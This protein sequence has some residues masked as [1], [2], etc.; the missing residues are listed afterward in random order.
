MKT[1]I[2]AGK[3]PGTIISGLLLV[4]ISLVFCQ[5]ATRSA[6]AAVEINQGN[7]PVTPE[8]DGVVTGTVTEES[9]GNPIQ[10]VEMCFQEYGGS[11]TWNL[12]NQTDGDGNYSITLSPGIYE[13]RAKISGYAFEYYDDAYNY[14]HR[15][16]VTVSDGQ[17]T[18][19]IDFDLSPGGVITGVVIET[20]S[21]NPLAGFQMELLFRDG[22]YQVTQ[23]DAN[24]AYQFTD[25]P[26]ANDFYVFAWDWPDGGLHSLEFWDNATTWDAVTPVSVTVGSSLRSNINF[27]LEWLGTVT[28]TVVYTDTGG[29]IQV[30]DGEGIVTT[31][32]IP[33]GA[34]TQ[35]T[36]IVYTAIVTPPVEIPAGFTIAGHSFSFTAYQDNLPLDGFTFARPVTITIS[37]SEADLVGID[38]D[39]LLLMVWDAD[40][41]A[42][43]DAA[44]G[45]YDRHMDENWL[46]V[47]ICHLSDFAWLGATEHKLFLPVM[48]R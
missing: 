18:P 15:I 33:G 4:L 36:A 25:V 42:W 21:E 12:C 6:E 7:D 29:I 20:G 37:Y 32:G 8:V 9:S 24:G 48:N 31:I 17:T 1:G 13:A 35:T 40:Q 28:E 41:G 11:Y 47:P 10:D 27:S 45:A 3:I 14:T 16:S 44:C 5:D 22:I 38:D 39:S 34:V 26:F 43:V 23:T 2:N 46:S 19:N 30:D